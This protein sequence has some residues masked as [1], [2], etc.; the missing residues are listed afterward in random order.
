MGCGSSKVQSEVSVKGY[1]SVVQSLVAFTKARR[2]DNEPRK[3]PEVQSGCW[4]RAALLRESNC[5]ERTV[6]DGRHRVKSDRY[7]DR[8]DSRVTAR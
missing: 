1:M 2:D 5:R 3:P 8:F 7:K 4:F 6:R